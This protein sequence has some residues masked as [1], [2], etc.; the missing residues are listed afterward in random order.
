MEEKRTLSKSSDSFF[1]SNKIHKRFRHDPNNLHLKYSCPSLSP[2]MTF[3]LCL[4]NL[5][6][7]NC[8]GPLQRASKTG[9]EREILGCLAYKSTCLSESSLDLFYFYRCH[10]HSMSRDYLSLE[11]AFISIW[12]LFPKSKAPG[13][14]LC[15]YL[16]Y[17]YSDSDQKKKKNQQVQISW[18]Q[19]RLCKHLTMFSYNS[20]SFFTP[21]SYSAWCNGCILVTF[22]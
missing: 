3:K 8:H 16:R 18:A 4:G 10:C 21:N 17:Y 2:E 13:R 11:I 6:W 19:T 9:R 12:G 5:L 1:S 22:E 14:M 15:G 7:A 20:S